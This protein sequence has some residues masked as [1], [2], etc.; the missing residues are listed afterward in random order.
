ME[1]IVERG[2]GVLYLGRSC[3]RCKFLKPSTSADFMQ[4][5]PLLLAG[6]PNST[7]CIQCFQGIFEGGIAQALLFGYGLNHG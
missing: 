2:G 6:F 7:M 1:H 5:L 4:A 3:P